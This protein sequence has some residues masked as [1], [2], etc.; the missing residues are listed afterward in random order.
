MQISFSAT[1]VPEDRRRGTGFAKRTE[2]GLRDHV[3]NAL[4]PPEIHD[5]FRSAAIGL[6]RSPVHIR[7]R[8][9]GRSA[10]GKGFMFPVYSA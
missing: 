2:L 5:T 3:P 4:H 1:S 10:Q 7:R 8:A 9:R 6:Q